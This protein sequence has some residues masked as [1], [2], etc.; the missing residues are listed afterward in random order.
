MSYYWFNR[1]EILQKAKKNIRRKKLL[2]IM[3]KT[4]KLSK[5]SQENVIKTCHKKKRTKLKSIKEKGIKNWFSI[6][7]SAKK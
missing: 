7:K 6:K 5:K 1:R 4:K 2:N 3:H